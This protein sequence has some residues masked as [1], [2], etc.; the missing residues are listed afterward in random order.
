M[1]I[2]QPKKCQTMSVGECVS[3]LKFICTTIH[4]WQCEEALGCTTLLSPL[5]LP[6]T[7]TRSAHD[8]DSPCFP[9]KI[10][11][12]QKSQSE[13]AI[14]NPS[15]RQ[16]V[17]VNPQQSQRRRRRPSLPW[18][19]HWESGV[20]KSVWHYFKIIHYSKN[21]RIYVNY[22]SFNYDLVNK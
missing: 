1:Q 10:P 18:G 19:L 20:G 15:T 14:S 2:V 16:A 8:W 7:P 21:N 12:A 17:S 6:P 5:F 9:P 4:C 22:T 11:S 13:L 3:Q